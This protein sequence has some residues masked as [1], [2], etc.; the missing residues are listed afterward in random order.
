MVEININYSYNPQLHTLLIIFTLPH[1]TPF[2]LYK[3]CGGGRRGMKGSVSHG[4]VSMT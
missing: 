4:A 1:Q 3:V 2:L